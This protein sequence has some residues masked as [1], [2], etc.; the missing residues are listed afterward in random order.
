MAKQNQ[1]ITQAQLEAMKEHQNAEFMRLSK[2]Q[3]IRMNSENGKAYQEGRTLTWSSPIVAGAYAT[4]I[5]LEVR[6]KINFTAGTTGTAGFTAGFP[7]NLMKKYDISFGN[8]IQNGVPYIHKVRDLMDSSGQLLKDQATGFK[9]PEVEAMVRKVPTVLVPG[10]NEVV[11]Q[12]NMPLNLIHP[13]TT[14]GILPIFSSGTRLQLSVQLPQVVGKDPL[15]NAVFVSD[16]FNGTVEVVGDINAVLCFRDY[17]S[18]TTTSAIQPNIE[19]T[20]MVQ[21]VELPSITGLTPSVFN[22]ASLKNPYM[23]TAL[24]SIVID[25]KQSDKFSKID[26]ITGYGLDK[27]EN[28]SSY[29]FRYGDDLGMDTYY[30]KFRA[31]YNNDLDSGVFGWNASTENQSDPAN[32]LG[33]A[34]LNLSGS[35]YTAS[36]I[37]F[38][39]NSVGENTGIASR[40]LTYGVLI[41]PAG[42]GSV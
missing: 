18:M 10:E 29:F 25:G 3:E 11:F 37:N 5:L 4:E 8:R 31:T 22:T 16:D 26:N 34:F 24:Y 32:K 38:R 30:R 9:N 12:V 15:D 27:Q 1:Q 19:G 6:A 39:V 14:N 33:S 20:Q 42:I 17:N 40:V 36:R 7:H 23:F 21:L 2:P 13:Q 28:N 35:G 41:N